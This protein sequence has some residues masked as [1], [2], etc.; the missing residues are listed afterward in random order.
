VAGRR[1]IST[2][3]LGYS[4]KP[5]ID[6]TVSINHVVCSVQPLAIN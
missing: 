6:D 3:A 1:Q 4:L 5:L 2:D